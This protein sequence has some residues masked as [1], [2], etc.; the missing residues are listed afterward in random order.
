MF[1]KFPYRSNN[2]FK[3]SATSI[4]VTASFSIL[5]SAC[6]APEDSPSPPIPKI[7]RTYLLPLLANQQIIAVD[8]Y[9][10]THRLLIGADQQPRRLSTFTTYIDDKPDKLYYPYFVYTYRNQIFYR[11]LW[12]ADANSEIFVDAIPQDNNG[13]SY[14]FCR[15]SVEG[16]SS[17]DSVGRGATIRYSYPK[18]PDNSADNI[19]PPCD[20]FNVFSDIMP[21]YDRTA[22]YPSTDVTKAID[23]IRAPG[24]SATDVPTIGGTYFNSFFAV[25][26]NTDRTVE[27]PGPKM[28]GRMIADQATGNLLWF[29]GDMLIT[30]TTISNANIPG[31]PEQQFVIKSNFSNFSYLSTPNAKLILFL[32]DNNVYVFETQD[33]NFT[34]ALDDTKKT[35]GL[36]AAASPNYANFF[37]IDSGKAFFFDGNIVQATGLTKDAQSGLFKTSEFIDLSA[38]NAVSLSFAQNFT[39]NYVFI[40]EHLSDGSYNLVAVDQLETGRH[41]SLIANLTT[42][43]YTELA[44]EYFYIYDQTANYTINA[45][46]NTA[47][48]YSNPLI[49]QPM[50]LPNNRQFGAFVIEDFNIGNPSPTHAIIYQDIGNHVYS[51]DYFDV[52]SGNSLYL[53]DLDY[54]SEYNDPN[55]G[56]NLMLSLTSKIIDTDFILVTST[57]LDNTNSL[58]LPYYNR[59][60]V[61]RVD[62]EG[63]LVRLLPEFDKVESI[64]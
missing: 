25:L 8:A 42:N 39:S 62:R 54:S 53:G 9:H 59:S 14:R 13:A 3:K 7:E 28:F 47:L 32:I 63:D 12:P 30:E 35:Y 56:S 38:S 52:A 5:L 2:S 11:G 60:M 64:R 22:D 20:N 4:V 24:T 48:D 29:P 40:N 26:P 50:N 31:N 55:L 43:A 10:P 49:N 1:F 44:G 23:L 6:L 33:P 19:N 27:V 17:L 41:R 34:T 15:F 21:E 18:T 45:F 37:R 51:L 16:G 58:G 46:Y 61:A 36:T 57:I